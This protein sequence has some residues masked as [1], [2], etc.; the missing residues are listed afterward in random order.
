MTPEQAARV[1]V[2]GPFFA[3]GVHPARSA[4]PDAWRVLA[5]LFE[6]GSGVFA[7]RVAAVRAF[8]AAGGRRAPKEVEE[9][10]AAS[11]THLGLVSR[12]LSPVLGCAAVL[13]RV[14]A[15]DPERVRWRSELGGAFPLS[16]PEDALGSGEDVPLSTV[17]DGVLRPLEAAALPLSVSPHILRGNAASALDGAARA[18]AHSGSPDAGRVRAA[19]S[20]LLDDPYLAGAFSGEGRAFRRRSCCLIYRAAPDGAGGLCGDCALTT[21]RH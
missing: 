7:E 20:E 5:D 2:L 11:V 10:V 17:V 9:R 12:L 8:L 21:R 4:A 6:S 15:L 13:G 1:A 19:A 14:P 18:A 16:L 3:F